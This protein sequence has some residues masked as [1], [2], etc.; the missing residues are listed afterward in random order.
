MAEGMANMND[1]KT[2]A[3]LAPWNF[4]VGRK[5]GARNWVSRYLDRLRELDANAVDTVYD[6]ATSCAP[7][8]SK[9]RFEIGLDIMF[10]EDPPG[11]VRTVIAMG[12]AVR[13]KEVNIN[14]SRMEDLS[15]DELR[16][17]RDMATKLLELQPERS[18]SD[19]RSADEG[20]GAA[21]SPE[22]VRH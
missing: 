6:H 10:A 16:L 21:G 3:N 4:Q 14:H 19:G 5:K 15:D 22:S 17:A 12:A 8:C 11:Y 1:E 9:S 2:K 7:C 13:P 20:N 18:E